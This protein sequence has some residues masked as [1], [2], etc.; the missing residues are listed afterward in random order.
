MSVQLL[1]PAE[2]LVMRNAFEAWMTPAAFQLAQE[3]IDALNA[4]GDGINKRRMIDLGDGTT[5]SQVRA[6]VCE[7]F[8]CA[9]HGT[10]IDLEIYTGNDG[11]YDTVFRGWSLE[12]KRVGTRKDKRG[13]PWFK[14]EPNDLYIDNPPW[15]FGVV[16]EDDAHDPN[17]FRT[18]GQVGRERWLNQKQFWSR[19]NQCWYVEHLDPPSAMLALPQR[20]PPRPWPP[21]PLVPPDLS[22]TERSVLAAF[23]CGESR[24]ARIIT[25]LGADENSQPVRDAF[26]MLVARGFIQAAPP[27]RYVLLDAG[28]LAN[29]NA[30]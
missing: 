18:V 6:K 23:A 2:M 25:I 29:D 22:T 19:G 3:H 17:V 10:P 11:G 27:Y 13:K 28:R 8:W 20:N 14:R 9:S 30:P 16:I 24:W 26:G 12:L 1:D 15:D 5:E 4:K 7:I 21:A